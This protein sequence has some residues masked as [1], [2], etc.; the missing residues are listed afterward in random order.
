MKLK[1]S[2]LALA[3][4][5][6]GCMTPAF[7]Q[8][9]Y[10]FQNVNYPDDTF[11]QFLGI[12]NSGIVAGYHGASINKGFTYDPATNVFTSENYPGSAQTQVTGINNSGKTVGF[13]ITSGNQNIGFEYKGGVFSPRGEP[14]TPFNQLLGQNDS[15]QASGYYSTNLAGTNP[16]H[17]YILEEFGG[18]FAVFTLPNAPNGA[19]ATGINNAQDVCGF[20]ID[21]NNVTHGWL[22]VTGTFTVL[23]YP[24]ASSTSALGLNN[25][26]LLVGSYTDSVGSHGFVYNVNTKKYQSVDDPDAPA[27]TTVVNGLNDNGV[28]VGFFG[29]SPDNTAF[30][31]TPETD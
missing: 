28:L 14:G 7:G 31:A 13:Y 17:A 18:V 20:F 23:D 4:A 10:S 6:A 5:V 21:G 27:G 12:N 19:Q 29:N 2:V 24:G 16:D 30:I 22:L 1:Y 15:G 26:G 3:L 9:K 25:K 11:T 8:V